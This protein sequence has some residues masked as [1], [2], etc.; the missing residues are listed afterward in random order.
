MNAPFKQAPVKG[1]DIQSLCRAIKAIPGRGHKPFAKFLF[2]TLRACMA[3]EFIQRKQ[4]VFLNV[5]LWRALGAEEA[6]SSEIEAVVNA[7][8]VYLALVLESP[9]FTDVLCEAHAHLLARGDGDGLGQYFTPPDVAD[10]AAVLAVDQVARYPPKKAPGEPFRIHEPACGAGSLLLGHLRSM[11]RGWL[12][13]EV[14]IE[15]IDIDPMCC[16]MTTLQ[17]VANSL[18]HNKRLQQVRVWCGNTL[19]PPEELMEFAVLEL[20]TEAQAEAI[21]WAKIDERIRWCV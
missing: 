5:P 19:L 3:A 10:L 4:E 11:P 20:K 16:A 8:R 17:F 21:T 1:A 13:P 2:N 14:V 6:Q 18:L 12:L 9:A 7:T 15:A